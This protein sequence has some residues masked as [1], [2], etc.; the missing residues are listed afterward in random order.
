M[1]SSNFAVC[2]SKTSWFVK[3]QEACGI[4]SSSGIRRP[5]SHVPLLDPVL[6]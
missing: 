3:K 4:L 6:F 2:G 5:L 1:L